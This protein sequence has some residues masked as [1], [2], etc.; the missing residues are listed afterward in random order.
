MSAVNSWGG[1]SLDPLELRDWEDKDIWA[2]PEKVGC[3]THGST[4]FLRSWE[5]ALHPLTLS[6]GENLLIPDAIFSLLQVLN[7][8]STLKASRLARQNPVLWGDPSEKLDA[9]CTNQCLFTPGK[10]W[11]LVGLFLTLWFPA[12]ARDSRGCP[13]SHH[14]L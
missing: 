3:L 14:W 8:A 1:C 7:C 12:K 11:E 5:L 9:R 4:I 13:K 10:S 6:R 2:A